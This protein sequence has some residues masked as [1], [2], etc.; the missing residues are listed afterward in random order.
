MTNH[1]PFD[2]LCDLADDLLS[3]DVALAAREH[4]GQCGDCAERFSALTSLTT[5]AAALPK[6]I[7]APADL[8]ADIH[9]D[10]SASVPS[11]NQRNMRRW[12]P[13]LAAAGALIAALSSLVTYGVMRDKPPVSAAL[14]PASAALPASLASAE[15]GYEK[16]V[17]DLQRALDDRRDSLAPS[18]VATVEQSL[19]IA[20]SAIAEARSALA[21]DPGNA[22][23][24]KLLASNYERKIDLLKR[25]AELEPRT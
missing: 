12:I 6:R 25:A 2:R 4:L 21:R 22:A 3:A 16:S 7:A 1:L 14:H 9:R 20:D 15:R 8:W 17:E 18:T 24:V 10:I 11:G 5:S 23:L 19:R 13:Q